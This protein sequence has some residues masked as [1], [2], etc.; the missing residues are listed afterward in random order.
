[1]SVDAATYESDADTITL[2]PHTMAAPRIIWSSSWLF[3]GL[4]RVGLH[5]TLLSTAYNLVRMARLG[6]P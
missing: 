3:R 1:M 6:V 4:D 5:F 2:A